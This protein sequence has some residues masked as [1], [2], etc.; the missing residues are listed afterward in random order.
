[1]SKQKLRTKQ[2]INE[3]SKKT[4][5]YTINNT[6]LR[7][8]IVLL[9]IPFHHEDV[10]IFFLKESSIAVVEKKIRI[11][12]FYEHKKIIRGDIT[13]FNVSYSVYIPSLICPFSSDLKDGLELDELVLLGLR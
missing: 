6:N 10:S 4:K 9:L 7:I 11:F 3:Q 8:N 13:C 12:T 5:A 1:M 2:T